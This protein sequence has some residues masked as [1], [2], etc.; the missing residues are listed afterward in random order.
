MQRR[1]VLLCPL[2]VLALSLGS[3]CKDKEAE[4]SGEA[5]RVAF[6]QTLANDVSLPAYAESRARA[7]GLSTALHALVDEVSA[8]N[9]RAAQQAWREA[10]VAWKET[11]AFNL[12]PAVDL[13]TSVTVDQWPVEQAHLETE[14]AGT[15]ALT[16]AYVA[17][18]GANRKGFHALEYLLFVPAA[19]AEALALLSE[20]AGAERRKAFLL[21]LAAQV[22]HPLQELETRWSE[23][24]A[25]SLSTPGEAYPS[26]KAAVDAYV[27]EAVFV[28]ELI[29]SKKLGKPLG[30]SS[31]GEAQPALE[32]SG[33]SDHSVADM[34]ANLRSLRHV[35]EGLSPLVA[36]AAPDTDASVQQLLANAQARVNDIPLPYRTALVEQRAAVE[37][38]YAATNQLKRILATEVVSALGVTLKFN[39]N[40]GD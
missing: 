16:E 12:G 22:E 18:L 13:R 5:L 31:G 21:A 33:W 17:S 25:Q 39:D 35:Y 40:D 27:N 7:Q 8:P 6:L 26:L 10:R 9:L 38:A 15:A 32:E 1:R 36:K 20:G 3:A 19:E 14:L 29:V 34:A 11:E 28:S 2:L 24:Y 30:L 37:T 23:G 4:D